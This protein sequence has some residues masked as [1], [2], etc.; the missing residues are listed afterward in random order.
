MIGELGS[1][2]VQEEDRDSLRWL[3]HFYM[4]NEDRAQN[5]EGFEELKARFMKSPSFL[6]MTK[7]R[8]LEGEATMLLR[9]LERRFGEIPEATAQRVF[10][11]SGDRLQRWGDR[12]LDAES[13]EDIFR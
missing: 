1:R 7:Q 10:T 2:T 3:A 4:A 12:V 13:L 6:E 11:A 8:F 5:L 9:L